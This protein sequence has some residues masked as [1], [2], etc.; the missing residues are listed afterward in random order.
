MSKKITHVA[1]LAIGLIGLLGIVL[2]AAGG[3]ASGTPGY[4]TIP[5]DSVDDAR[6]QQIETIAN[7]ILE[8]GLGV[9][10]EMKVDQSEV[11]DQIYYAVFIPEGIKGDQ[12]EPG[13][14]G[15]PGEKGAP[16]EKG[17]TGPE[18]PA[19]P[20]GPM[21]PAGP[22]GDTGPQGPQGDPGPQGPEGQ[23]GPMGP[24]GPQGPAGTP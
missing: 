8:K 11:G 24:M 18:G 6:A 19:G 20:I 3:I 10:V 22:K 4:V 21:G 15:D 23:Q 9:I 14:K 17:E 12:G 1:A 16:G 7:S 5:R 13:E 2:M